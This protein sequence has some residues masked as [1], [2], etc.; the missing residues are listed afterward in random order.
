MTN[1]PPTSDNPRLSAKEISERFIALISEMRSQEELSLKRVQDSTG[2]ALL[3]S[4]NKKN[5]G[6]SQKLADGWFY[7]L[8]YYPD[9][10]GRKKGIRLDFENEIDRFSDMQAVCSVNFERFHNA[11]KAMGYR[12][13]SINGEL[14]QPQEWRYYRDDIAI[15]IIPEFKVNPIGG[16]PVPTCVKSIGTLN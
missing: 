15:T 4:A 2:L 14:G 16:K 11:L 8:W 7:A 6:Y 13:V 5:F 10:A 3:E 1:Q 12:D 9:V